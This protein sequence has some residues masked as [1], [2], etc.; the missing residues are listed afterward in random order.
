MTGDFFMY[1]SDPF[2]PSNELFMFVLNNIEVTRLPLNLDDILSNKVVT[3]Q[4]ITNI[5]HAV[6]NFIATLGRGLAYGPQR[7]FSIMSEGKF[8][9]EF[10]NGLLF[11]IPLKQD[12]LPLFEQLLKQDL[13]TWLHKEQY[14]GAY[15]VI[16]LEKDN[17]HIV[18][19][20]P[21]EKPIESNWEK[22]T[23]FVPE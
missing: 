15:S 2:N 6:T 14:V 13:Y 5:S 21:M 1:D 23:V 18:N 11:R 16:K 10:I 3:D 12:N 7:T 19:I 22:A 4:I 9:P 8:I 17:I 20:M